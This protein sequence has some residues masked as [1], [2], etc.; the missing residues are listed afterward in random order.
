MLAGKILQEKGNI[1]WGSATAWMVMTFLNRALNVCPCCIGPTTLGLGLPL[2]LWH[3]GTAC[4]VTPQAVCWRAGWQGWEICS[5]S[6]V[7]Q[8]GSTIPAAHRSLLG[9]PFLN[10]T[11]HQKCWGDKSEQV[12][13]LCTDLCFSVCLYLGQIQGI[14]GPD[15]SHPWMGNAVPLMCSLIGFFSAVL[16]PN[17]IYFLFC[18]H[19]WPKCIC[20]HL[21]E[22]F[23]V[24]VHGSHTRIPQ[25]PHFWHEGSRG[26]SLC[27]LPVA[28]QSS[29]LTSTSC[30]RVQKWSWSS[31]GCAGC[32]VTGS[33]GVR[34]VEAE[35]CPWAVLQGVC[36]PTLPSQ[37]WVSWRVWESHIC[38][39][40]QETGP[41]PACHNVLQLFVQYVL[42][43]LKT[44]ISQRKK[45][46]WGSFLCR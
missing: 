29:T 17:T 13:D 32:A 20:P 22:P 3:P 14:S 26:L 12:G 33:S 16:N 21:H 36:Q 7:T 11:Q 23:P 9:G 8:W 34:D 4:P 44:L 31:A 38:K 37:P 30:I 45:S 18:S 24:S 28:G 40:D 42:G 46:H 41:E 5:V 39:S 43:T 15:I 10:S 1:P 25:T 35:L 2:P 6:A 27:H 19:Q